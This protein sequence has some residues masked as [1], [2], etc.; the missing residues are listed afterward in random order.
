MVVSSAT[1]F[2]ELLALRPD[3]A[4]LRKVYYMHENQLQV[5]PRAR[6]PPAY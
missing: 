1:H 2:G 6:H 3:L 4:P 5:G